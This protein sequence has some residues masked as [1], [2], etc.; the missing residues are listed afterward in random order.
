M[1][2][3]ER[4]PAHWE[5]VQLAAIPPIRDLTRL[6]TPT[7]SQSQP[8]KPRIP[9][10]TFASPYSVSDAPTTHDGGRSNENRGTARLTKAPWHSASIPSQRNWSRALAVVHVGKRL[11]GLE[12]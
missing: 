4:L 5:L 12:A 1:A 10:L 3:L 8:D 7:R 2:R 11:S 9:R 6:G